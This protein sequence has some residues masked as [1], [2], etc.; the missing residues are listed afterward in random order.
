MLRLGRGVRRDSVRRALA[1]RRFS[2]VVYRGILEG[3]DIRETLAGIRDAGSPRD[4]L[5]LLA[6]LASHPSAPEDVLRELGRE[7]SREVL[8]S[9]SMN[10]NLP[11]DMRRALLAH[12]DDE[13]RE[14]ASH[15]FGRLR[16]H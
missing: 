14:S 7:S 3:E 1:R 8:I 16:R 9:L 2:V 12:E 10:R 4:V 11:E 5:P 15:V 6:W 13:V